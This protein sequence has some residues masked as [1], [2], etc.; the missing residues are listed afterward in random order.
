MSP[1][2]DPITGNL[3]G[4]VL[5]ILIIAIPLAFI[6]SLILLALYRRAVL[7]SMR[8]R[9]NAGLADP[10]SSGMSSG[11]H[12]PV[13]TPLEIAVVDPAAS[14]TGGSDP[15]GLY[16]GLL[17]GPWRV[18]AFYTIAGLAYSLVT[19]VIFF[20]AT[21]TEFL[22]LR[23]L[24]VFWYYAW[25]IAITICLVAAATWRTRFKVFAI[26]FLSIVLLGVLA[27]MTG[28]LLGWLEIIGLWLLT[29]LPAALLLLVFLNRRIQAVGPL[30]LTFM[31]FAV[32]GSLLLPPFIANDA[33][34]L[35][36]IVDIGR[37]FGLGG[38]GIFVAL[39]FIGFALFGMAGWLALQ[40][41]GSM[42]RHKWISEQSIT[43]DMIWLLFGIFQSIGLLFEG[44]FWFL[45]SLLSFIVYKL[46]AWAL[47]R[48]ADRK[49]FPGRRH[50][51]LL[52][53]RVFSLG[54]RSEQL[55]DALAM[56]WRFTGS[57]R[58]IAGPDL[59]TTTMEPHE[60]LDF[61]GGRL[62]RRF[63]DNPQ[64]LEL[65]IA[66]SDSRPDYDGQFRVNDFF[67]HDDT[68]RLVLSRLVRE[69]DAVLMDLRG[70]SAQNAG[71]LFEIGELVN[72]M[73]IDQVVFIVDGSTDEGFLQQALQE[74]W[75]H[76]GPSSPN[77]LATV[78]MLRLFRLPQLGATELQKLLYVLSSAVKNPPERR[79]VG[80]PLVSESGSH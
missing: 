37:A 10:A 80:S 44:E 20:R 58:L 59:A 23:F 67:C 21:D 30:A 9:A 4:L 66:Q 17:R 32:T 7:R 49:T 72:L 15:H 3:P 79:A 51:S 36:L 75:D 77:R 6:T 78:G 14:P 73:P 68:W 2:S 47:F 18:A 28:S 70:F 33:G 24:I 46:V 52:V 65:R 76:M 54:K 35:S 40:A 71:C 29:N 39:L 27:A 42:Y 56:Y 26:Y 64:T 1:P 43:M 22:I 31:I 55:F 41:I 45:A 50:P 60:F 13:Q 12:E 63:I 53:L 38:S 5:L 19:T 62:S 11:S 25:P 69:S 48:F 8:A 74:A 61:I 16:A 57:I 34:R